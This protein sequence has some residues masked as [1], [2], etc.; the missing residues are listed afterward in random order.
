MARFKVLSGEP[1]AS[2]GSSSGMTGMTFERRLW[3][4]DLKSGGVS[5]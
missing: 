5:G 1:P 2:F 3:N 4:A